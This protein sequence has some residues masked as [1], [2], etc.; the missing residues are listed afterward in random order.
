M[1]ASDRYYSTP[2]KNPDLRV[3]VII[4]LFNE[5]ITRSLG[6]AAAQQLA[7]LGVPKAGILQI[8]VPGAWELPYAAAR[9]LSAGQADAVVAC[10]CVVRGETGHYDIVANESA[11]GLMRVGL[12]FK[13]PVMNAVLTVEN[14]T[15]ARA[16][17]EN[18]ATNKGAEAA[19]SL[20]ELLNAF[21]EPL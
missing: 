2:L 4:A 16:R 12:D 3:A 7:E 20:V 9:I 1:Q 13:K 6:R 10:G 19:R 15:Q 21:A 8:F 17:A 14:F 11:S 5:D 18:D